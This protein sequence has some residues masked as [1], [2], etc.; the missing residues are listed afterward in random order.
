MW[1][2]WL[3]LFSL[4]GNGG[5]ASYSTASAAVAAVPQWDLDGVSLGDTESEVIA[6]WGK[7]NA[8]ETDEWYPDC[9]IWSYMG[10]R[11][12]GLCDGEVSFVQVT[13]RADKVNLNGRELAM[14][15]PDLRRALGN[16]EFEA[17]DGWGV[18]HGPEAL[19][20]FVDERGK[21]VSLDLFGSEF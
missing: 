3:L 11:N 2:S 10:G 18:I 9:V 7:P 12:A 15:G 13:S 5:A 4:M 21:L 19:K 17:E 8:V 6:A 14:S 1:F 20:V 16:P